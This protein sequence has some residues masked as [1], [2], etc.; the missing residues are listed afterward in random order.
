MNK[1]FWI[2]KIIGFTLLALVVAGALGYVVM[3]LWN[4]VLAV[5]ISGVSLI[6]FW[7]ALG[8]LLLSKILFGG[9]SGR[10]GGKG[11]HWKNEMK[12]KWQGMTPEEREKIKQEWRNR[13]RMWG[14]GQDA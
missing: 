11:S 13:C 1:Q 7:Q 14:T 9:F 2:K 8:L 6:S 3:L 12:E 4:Q 10:C 5:V